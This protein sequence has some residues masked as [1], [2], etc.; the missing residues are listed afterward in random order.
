MSSTISIHTHTLAA[1]LRPI[2]TVDPACEVV[3]IGTPLHVHLV[4][5]GTASGRPTVC[6]EVPRPGQPSVGLEVSLAS[7]VDAMQV[8][9]GLALRWA[10]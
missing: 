7:L 1:T 9:A 5:G 6:L 8:C 4:E 10:K 2:D 3:P